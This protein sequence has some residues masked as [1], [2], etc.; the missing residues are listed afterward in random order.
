M[1]TKSIGVL[2]S[3]QMK[4]LAN[5]HWQKLLILSVWILLFTLYWHTSQRVAPT[6]EEKLM[7]LASWF[8]TDIWGPIIFLAAFT[9]QPLVFFPTFI[10]TIVSGMLY[11]PM[12]G[13]LINIIGMNCAASVTYVAARLVGISSSNSV[14]E[15]HP[16]RKHILQLRSRTFETILTLHLLYVPFDLMNYLAGFMN[17]NW[18]QFAAATA[19]GTIPSGLAYVLFGNSLG[20]FEQIVSGRPNIN[21]PLL[22]FSVLLAVIGYMATRYFRRIRETRQ[23]QPAINLSD[24]SSS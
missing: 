24:S 14:A 2:A 10:M 4:D 17:L 7:L 13:M 16:L 12:W 20:S 3:R 5:R 15:N 8:L 1:S 21:L 9:F 23:P 22:S 6:L 11:G 18:R 19:I